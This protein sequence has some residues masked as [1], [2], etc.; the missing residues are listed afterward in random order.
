M[1]IAADLHIHSVLSACADRDMTPNNLVNM[2]YVK[3]LDAIALTDHNAARN[4]P[5]AYEAASRRGLLLLPGLE[6]TS[7]EEVHLLAYFRGI[8]T[9]LRFEGEVVAPALPYVECLG[10]FGEQWVMNGR[11]EIVERVG[12]W[13]AAPLALDLE[14]I[15]RRI[16]AY[17]GLAVPAHIE[18]GNGIL[19]VLG[20]LPEKPRFDALETT[21]SQRV[22]YPTIIS[23]DAH[24]LGAILERKYLLEVER[25]DVG[26]LMD[27]LH[28]VQ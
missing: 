16:R 22:P 12:N 28:F 24:S 15:V 27:A 2:A 6:L 19:G 11:D 3:G 23:S 10:I 18:R 20:F 13:L 21:S 14:E 26:A 25:C 7:H 17:G 1:K 4:L 8:D 5:A 9:A